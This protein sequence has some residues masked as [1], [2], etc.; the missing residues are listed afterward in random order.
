MGVM[1]H[2]FFAAFC[3]LHAIIVGAAEVEVLLVNNVYTYTAILNATSRNDTTA[4]STGTFIPMAPVI[5]AVMDTHSNGFNILTSTLNQTIF[6]DDD[7]ES[8]VCSPNAVHSPFLIKDMSEVYYTS[9]VIDTT[10]DIGFI[11]ISTSGEAVSGDFLAQIENCTYIS[12]CDFY[13]DNLYLHNWTLN[14]E[15]STGSSGA[16]VQ[17]TVASNALMGLTYCA[18]SDQDKCLFQNLLKSVNNNLKFGL[19]LN[20]NI[21]YATTLALDSVGRATA[22]AADSPAPPTPTPSTLQLGYFEPTYAPYLVYQRPAMA[23]SSLEFFI[24]MTQNFELICDSAIGASATAPTG[25]SILSNFSITSYPMTV[26][27]G[28]VCLTLPQQF[29]DN[30]VSWLN[31]NSTSASRTDGF[32]TVDEF[33]AL[34]P[35]LQFQLADATNQ[36]SNTSTLNNFYIPLANLLIS[37][38]AFDAQINT[39]N[40]TAPPAISLYNPSCDC[41]QEYALGIIRGASIYSDSVNNFNIPSIVL[42]TLALQGLYFAA[43]M[44]T[45]VLGLANKYMVAIDRSSNGTDISP[46]SPYVTVA[47]LDSLMTNGGRCAAPAYCGSGSNSNDGF[48]DSTSTLQMLS[49]T[50]SAPECSEYFFTARAS[51]NSTDCVVD[52]GYYNVGLVFL[53]IFVFLDILSYFTSQYSGLS[54]CCTP[55]G[56]DETRA[57]YS[58]QSVYVTFLLR[59]RHFVSHKIEHVIINGIGKLSSLVV[60]AILVY[61]LG[62][63]PASA[64]YAEAGQPPRR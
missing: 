60:D 10:H 4:N 49:N 14:N 16:Q 61:V 23:A 3:V 28:S 55:L 24:L 13:A 54:R 21:S 38:A 30:L 22:T 39:N 17:Q 47:S 26:D 36:S 52:A 12:S 15:F 41:V 34:L 57:Y 53:S 11:N 58:T 63:V 6:L 50:C 7:H 9:A 19:D 18:S 20:M 46:Y 40:V 29:Y 33:S 32:L 42:G 27:S 43:D 5:A 2:R 45:G 51:A 8:T 1:G 48:G 31:L 62:W 25:I 44:E 56:V 64:L 37:W 35:V 59:A